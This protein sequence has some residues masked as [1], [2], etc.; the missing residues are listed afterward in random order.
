MN[1]LFCFSSSTN[2]VWAKSSDQECWH[3]GGHAA[4]CSGLRDC[5]PW[6]VQHREGYCRLHQEGVRQK[7]Q[8]HMALHR[9]PQLRQLRHTRNET[10]HLFLP[11]TSRHFAIQIRINTCSWFA[12][13]TNSLS[14]FLLNMTVAVF[15]MLNLRSWSNWSF[16]SRK[17]IKII[18][19]TC[20][21]FCF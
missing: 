12:F 15:Y 16:W 13:C 3:G 5:S 10:F 17:N 4:G 20:F 2:H 21:C 6:E 18:L 1:V 7:V 11:R 8:P 14:V 9:W 19:I